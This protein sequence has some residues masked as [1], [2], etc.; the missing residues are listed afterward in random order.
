MTKP[1]I[2]VSCTARA[3]RDRSELLLAQSFDHGGFDKFADLDIT[4]SNRLGLSAAYNQKL[5]K[6]AAS[7]V[8]FIVFA[9]DDVYMDDLKLADKLQAAHTGLGY[10]IIGAAGAV[11]VKVAEPTLWHLM[12]ERSQHRGFVHHFTNN[13]LI[14]CSSFGVTPSEVVLID[15]VFMAVHLPSV[16]EKGWEFNENYEFHHYD[17]ASCLD[18][19][20]AG[21]SLG[22]YP[23][24]LI[25]ESPGLDSLSNP[26]WRASNQRFLAEYG[27]GGSGA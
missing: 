15:G 25:H 24:H 22:V 12:A 8:E 16:L 27:S 3:E 18:A 21:L 14:H 7:G 2:I 17:L 23:I 26:A 5:R 19:K 6:Y 9:H 20:K 4:W 11:Q 1:I 10:H 13:G